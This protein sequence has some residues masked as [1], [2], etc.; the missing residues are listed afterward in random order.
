MDPMPLSE[1]PA[2]L[3]ELNVR[4]WYAH[5]LLQPYVGRGWHVIAA[6]ICAMTGEASYQEALASLVAASWAFGLTVADMVADIVAAA[7][8]RAPVNRPP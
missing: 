4:W 6:S 2:T 1:D 7:G 3:R 5:S 8:L